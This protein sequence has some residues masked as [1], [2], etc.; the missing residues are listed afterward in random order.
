MRPTPFLL[1]L[2]AIVA[3]L[4]QVSCNG[5]VDL[6]NPSISELDAAD[7]A[8]GLQ[9]RKAKTGPKRTFQV[10]GD[11]M[12]GSAAPVADAPSSASTSTEL[13]PAPTPA[14]PPEPALDPSVINKLR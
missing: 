1:T 4:L 13:P 2:A 11:G 5:T 8:W 9:P 6:R 3:G 7:A 14:T 10:P 12:G